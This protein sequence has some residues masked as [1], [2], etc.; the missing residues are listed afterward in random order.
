MIS[1]LILRRVIDTSAL[2]IILVC[3]VIA[4]AVLDG[5]VRGVLVGGLGFV[6]VLLWVDRSITR[7]LE[8]QVITRTLQSAAQIGENG[9][10]RVAPPSYER[11][12]QSVV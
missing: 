2:L 4:Y 1:L 6:P 10:L 8:C 5:L 9:Q 3:L 7:R 11:H 12:T